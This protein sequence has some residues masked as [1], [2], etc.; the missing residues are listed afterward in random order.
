MATLPLIDPNTGKLDHLAIA[1]RARLRAAREYGSPDYPPNCLRTAL[2]WCNERA[3]A[4]RLAW[5]RDHGLPDDSQTTLA[6]LPAW[7]SSGD[8]YARGS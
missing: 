5:R 6:V 7:G 4:E 2:E 3:Q 8:S 1:E